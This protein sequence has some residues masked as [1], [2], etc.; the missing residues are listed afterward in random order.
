MAT[1]RSEPLD[2]LFDR[3]AFLTARELRVRLGENFGQLAVGLVA[4]RVVPSYFG[5]LHFRIV[6]QIDWKIN[7]KVTADNTTATP[8]RHNRSLPRGGW[9]ARRLLSGC[10]FLSLMSFYAKMIAMLAAP[11]VVLLA[12]VAGGAFEKLQMS[13]NVA[14]ITRLS[15]YAV[16][17]GKLVHELQKERGRSSGFLASGGARFG[18]EL[19]AQ[20]AVTNQAAASAREARVQRPVEASSTD[21]DAIVG[22]ADEAL[23]DLTPLRAR[24]TSRSL[25]PSDAVRS[26]TAMIDALLAAAA[27][28]PD[29]CMDA[30]L[31]R[32]LRAYAAF[33]VLEEQTGLERAA[34][35]AAFAR[36]E[37]DG[38]DL[39]DVYFALA[40]QEAAAATFAASARRDHGQRLER[41]ASDPAVVE[42]GRMQA[43]ALALTRQGGFGV[44]PEAW[45]GAATAKLERLFAIESSLAQELKSEAQAVARSAR[46][47]LA[48]Y[49]AGAAVAIVSSALVGL[50]ALRSIRRPLRAASELALSVSAQ[51]AASLKQQSEAATETA[52]A[53]TETTAAASAIRQTAELAVRRAEAMTEAA[54]RGMSAG[55][56]GIAA[57]AAGREAMQRIRAEVLA[58]AE[59]IEE[60]GERSEEVD[61][62]A[63][64][65][66]SLADSSTILAINASIEAAGAGEHGARFGLV[67]AEV[68]RLSERS[69]GAGKDIRRIMAQIRA[70]SESAAQAAKEGERQT[71]S[72]A[73]RIEELGE[74]I[75]TI[76][77]TIE[78][79]A[80]IA[81]GIASEADQQLRG[82]G[83]I[84][85]SMRHIRQAVAEGASGLRQI[86][87][88]AM[89]LTEVNTQIVTVL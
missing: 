51:V 81:S 75:R 37:L 26:Y 62:I 33:L 55:E 47:G 11:L 9:P 10:I 68:R 87:A 22:A 46:S 20:R 29:H 31:S 85:D 84:A 53:V 13:R 1:P 57:M 63:R 45:F 15:A 52:T 16:E 18:E 86:E 34:L 60:L 19:E 8:E 14:E 54:T 25:S 76:Q 66:N 23:S 89:L 69:N 24:V 71:K 39:K 38:E 70:A 4:Q 17:L 61:A 42:A 12:F 56:L 83:Q 82:A 40:K 88:S 3:D 64:A 67:A 48:L 43:V 44:D 49:L 74:A 5:K 77:G 28:L 78:E 7:P 30:R 41:L 80:T 32:S 36:D 72:G 35:S 50:L 2:H 27:K 65:V 73:R 79:S 58:I 21:M 59:R 6:R